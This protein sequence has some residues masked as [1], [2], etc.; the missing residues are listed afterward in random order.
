MIPAEFSQTNSIGSTAW[1]Q[2]IAGETQVQNNWI[3]KLHA[4]RGSPDQ[5]RTR[6]SLKFRTTR[7]PEVGRPKLNCGRKRE[8]SST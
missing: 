8:K 6:T 2:E 7:P 4:N 1:S 5:P 3:L